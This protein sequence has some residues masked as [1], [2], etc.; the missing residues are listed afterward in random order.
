MVERTSRCRLVD[1][2]W[3]GGNDNLIIYTSCP[4]VESEVGAGLERHTR[5]SLGALL[6]MQVV[7]HLI[8]SVD[9][10]QAIKT[11]FSNAADYWL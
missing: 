2:R 8:P 1:I 3:P 9:F 4:R 10:S 11:G 5:G 7:L 6:P